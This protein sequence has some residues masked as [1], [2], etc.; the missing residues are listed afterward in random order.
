M[1]ALRGQRQIMRHARRNWQTIMRLR[2]KYNYPVEKVEGR[3]ESSTE[4]IDQWE[5]RQYGYVPTEAAAG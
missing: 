3:W 2:H 5:Q 1:A 4:A